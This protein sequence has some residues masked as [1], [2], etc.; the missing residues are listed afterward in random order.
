MKKQGL[1]L[2]SAIVLGVS[3]AL[4]NF[5]LVFDESN[6]SEF[7]N[8]HSKTYSDAVKSVFAIYYPS[9]MEQKGISGTGFAINYQN[10]IIIVT[11]EHVV[12]LKNQI[13]ELTSHTNKQFTAKVIYSDKEIDLAFLK[14]T[15][16]QSI[17]T[18]KLNNSYLD[19]HIGD[20]VF[21]IGNPYDLLFSY[22]DGSLSNVLRQVMFG[23]DYDEILLQTNIEVNP[24]NSGG[25]LLNEKGEVIGIISSTL[26]N[27]TGISLAIPTVQL[28]EHLSKLNRGMVGAQIVVDNDK[29]VVQK[30][31]QSSPASIAG[32]QTDDSILSINGETELTFLEA[33]KHFE[34][35]ECNAL[36]LTVE[37]NGEIIT[38]TVYPETILE[39]YSQNH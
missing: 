16:E 14:L 33:K 11:N 2:Y 13:Y 5:Y 7:S 19:K 36:E 9:S 35:S 22:S 39:F 23:D 3:F 27:T 29:I 21:T 20:Y 1:V 15:E 26:E 32:L 34:Y 28:E 10:Q 8:N 37:R 12:P 24:G 18:L 25:P 6:R 38:L 4:T 17:P 31:E 30:V